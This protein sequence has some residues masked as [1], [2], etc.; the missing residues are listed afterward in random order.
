MLNNDEDLKGTLYTDDNDNWVISKENMMKIINH[1]EEKIEKLESNLPEEQ[2]ESSLL[3]SNYCC[4]RLDDY[5]EEIVDHH[6]YCEAL[7]EIA[8]IKCDNK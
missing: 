8:R 3:K 7:K 4:V 1:Y 2:K 5:T 6:Q